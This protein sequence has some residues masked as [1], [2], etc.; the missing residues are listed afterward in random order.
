MNSAVQVTI[1]KPGVQ[2]TLQDHGRAAYHSFGVPAAGPMDRVAAKLANQLAGNPES[3]S[4]MEFTLIG[5]ELEIEGTGILAITGGDF[6]CTLDGKP[7][8]MNQAIPVAGLSRLKI[9]R[10]TRGCRGYLAI[11]GNWELRQWLDSCSTS[12]QFDSL[13]TPDSVIAKGKSFRVGNG[14]QASAGLPAHNVSSP[15]NFIQVLAGPEYHRLGRAVIVEFL[16]KEFIISAQSNR[17]GYRLK[18]PLQGYH[19][20]LEIISSGVVPGTIQLVPSGQLIIL[21][22]DAQTTGGYPRIAN[23]IWKDQHKLAQMKPGDSLR[24][25]LTSL[26]EAHQ[27]YNGH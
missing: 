14:N 20:P 18:T 26:Q 13:L 19:D 24:F 12:P 6:P 5:P 4:V 3:N 17:M 22:A 23:V 27:L 15:D 7:I 1:L 21:M 9:G 2:T 25:Q 10:V 16:K 8:P 11:A